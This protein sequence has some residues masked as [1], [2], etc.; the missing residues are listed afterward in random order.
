MFF[1]ISLYIALLVFGLGL[2][3]KVSNWFRYSIGTGAAEIPTSKRVSA[4]IKGIIS[5]LFSANI[6]TLIKVFILDVVL[7]Q[8]ILRQDKMRWV[9]HMCI[10]L[11]FML[12]LLMHALEKFISANLFSSYY[13]TVNPFM[14]LRDLFGAIVI[15]GIA[16]AIFRRFALKAP[17]LKTNS[18]DHYA[19]IIVALIMVWLERQIG[20]ATR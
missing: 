13:S 16:I 15:V 18:M 5:T 10:Y 9:M 2:I 6:F 4:A 11:A 8:K 20:V 17:R 3:Y 12:L 14:F 1:S 19:I 7:Q